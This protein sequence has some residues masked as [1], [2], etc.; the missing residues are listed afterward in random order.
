[1]LLFDTN[2]VT[3]ESENFASGEAE[4]TEKYSKNESDFYDEICKNEVLFSEGREGC[5]KTK[6]SRRS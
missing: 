3:F 5:Y 1:M 6:K 4:I 2:A